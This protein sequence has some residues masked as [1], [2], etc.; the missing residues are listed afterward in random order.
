MNRK[1]LSSKKIIQVN[2]K[3]SNIIHKYLYISNP[4]SKYKTTRPH[5]NRSSRNRR[6]F[7]EL[8]KS[9]YLNSNTTNSWFVRVEF[10]PRTFVEIVHCTRLIRTNLYGSNVTVLSDV[11]NLLGKCLRRTMIKHFYVES[12]TLL[13]IDGVEESD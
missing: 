8:K 4:K 11:C 6:I 3:Y 1:C 5:F 13:P 9:T 2:I 7:S 12:H 10:P